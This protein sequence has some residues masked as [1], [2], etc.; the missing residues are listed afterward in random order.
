MVTHQLQVER[1]TGKVRQSETDVLPLCHANN[2][3]QA[4]YVDNLVRFVRLVLE[5]C[6]RTDRHADTQIYGH[7]D[8]C[9]IS[10]R[11]RHQREVIRRVNRRRRD[12]TAQHYAWAADVVLVLVLRGYQGANNC[13]NKRYIDSRLDLPPRRC[14]TVVF[15]I[16]LLLTPRS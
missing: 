11:H 1:R 3:Q 14:K 5:I 9:S 12:G 4:T 10:H 8:L 2:L 15:I 13:T 7:A 16:P 6:S